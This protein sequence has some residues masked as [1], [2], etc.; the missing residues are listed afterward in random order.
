V[1][2]KSREKTERVPFVIYADFESCLVPVHDDSGVLDEYVPS[3]FCA[4]TVSADPEFETESVTYSGRDCMPVFYDPLTSEQRRIAVILKDYHEMLPLTREEQE[5]FDQTRACVAYN[6]PFSDLD[7]KTMHHNH[8]YG[9]IHRCIVQR[10][11][12]SN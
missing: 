12:S 6:K 11:Q 3:G 1:K 5:R 2:W 10:L 9:E 4:Y 7:P 8:S